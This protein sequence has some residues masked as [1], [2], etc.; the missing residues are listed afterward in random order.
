MPESYPS[1]LP[2]PIPGEENQS[3]EFTIHNSSRGYTPHDY[4]DLVV[5]NSEGTIKDFKLTKLDGSQLDSVKSQQQFLMK[6]NS[7]VYNVYPDLRNLVLNLE[8]NEYAS[9]ISKI[10]IKNNSMT[11]SRKI[12]MAEY[13]SVLLP[14]LN[15]HAGKGGKIS[16]DQLHQV[17]DTAITKYGD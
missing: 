3:F 12:I 10:L 6:I 9:Q 2:V 11:I 14:E 1:V 13:L 17:F 7:K 5:E 15:A 16:K 8:K 4:E